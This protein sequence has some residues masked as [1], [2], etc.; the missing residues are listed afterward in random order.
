MIL[1]MTAFPA[2][3]SDPE[4]EVT[5]PASGRGRV[6]GTTRSD[7]CGEKKAGAYRTTCGK[8]K[9]EEENEKEGGQNSICIA[10]GEKGSV[11]KAS[12]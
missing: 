11:K 6:N 4:G 8:D 5:H 2:T 9:E 3:P 12:A 7:M 10:V 1:T